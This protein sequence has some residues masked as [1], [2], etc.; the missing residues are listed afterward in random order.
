MRLN[1]PLMSVLVEQSLQGTI[2]WKTLDLPN[3]QHLMTFVLFKCVS[4]AGKSI[5]NKI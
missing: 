1:C 4:P 2:R 5:Y 3:L